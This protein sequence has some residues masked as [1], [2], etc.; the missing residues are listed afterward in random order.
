MV[1]KVNNVKDAEGQS[2]SMIQRYLFPFRFPKEQYKPLSAGARVLQKD[3]S[4]TEDFSAA[5][6]K[7]AGRICLAG[8]KAS[9]TVSYRVKDGRFSILRHVVFPQIFIKPEASGAVF[10]YNFHP[11]VEL[12]LDGVEIRRER[13]ISASYKGNLVLKSVFMNGAT[14]VRS[15]YPSLR[16]PALIEKVEVTNDTKT[17]VTFTAEEKKNRLTDKSVSVRGA[18]VLVLDGKLEV[19]SRSVDANGDFRSGNAAQ[20]KK[21]LVPGAS[22]VCYI[23]HYAVRRGETLN[24]NA[25]KEIKDRVKTL[26]GLSEGPEL[27]SGCKE[28]DALF[29]HALA[30]S[31]ES[32]TPEQAPSSDA[33][34]HASY[35]LPYLD[36][37]MGDTVPADARLSALKEAFLAGKVDANDTLCAYAADTLLGAAGPYPAD[38]ESGQPE[39]LSSAFCNAVLEGALGIK[40]V[41][42]TALSFSP[43]LRAKITDLRYAGSDFDLDATGDKIVIRMGTKQYAAERGGIFDFSIPAWRNAC[44]EG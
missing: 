43:A 26:Q 1:H 17:K 21:L 44:T 27:Q 12:M 42:P 28:L 40:Q 10:S 2:G 14:I 35:L 23:V 41:S 29:A 13:L 39:A 8:A 31:A 9:S 25:E 34:Q 18:S 20:V 5:E 36:K 22:G 6:G 4:V 30:R 33:P 24:F 19:G 11:K 32:D 3:K 38:S 15:F 37:D 7:L 16:Y